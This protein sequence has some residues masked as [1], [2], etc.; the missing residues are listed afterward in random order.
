MKNKAE[1]LRNIIKCGL[2]AA[3]IAVLSLI[4]IQTP[5]GVPITLQTFSI[6]LCGYFLGG[7]MGFIATLVYVC[8][9]AVGL[10][11]FSGMRGGLSVLTGPTGGFIIG[12]L[13]M[14]FLCRGKKYID[15]LLFGVL[16][17]LICHACGVLWFAYVTNRTVIEAFFAA[18]FGFIPK[19]VISVA[20]A[21]FAARLIKARIPAKFV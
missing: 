8:L 10:P 1:A 6:A 5:S 7:K 12:F 9:G 15:S 4:S 11:V 18:S 21:C 19:D 16:G 2:F 17:L 3:I 20:V 14:A 13:P